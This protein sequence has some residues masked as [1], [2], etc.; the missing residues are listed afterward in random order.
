MELDG[1]PAAGKPFLCDATKEP[2]IWAYGFRN[3]FRFSFRPSNGALYLGDVGQS[4]REELDVVVAGGNYGW[5]IGGKARSTHHPARANAPGMHPRCSTT[6]SVGT[7]VTGGA[8][9]TGTAY[10][11]TLLQGL[12]V[13][14]DNVRNRIKYLQFD[15]NDGLIGGVNALQDSQPPL[16]GPVAFTRARTNPLLRGHQH[17]RYLPD[18]RR[19]GLLHA[20]PLPRWRTPEE[21]SGASRRTEPRRGRRPHLPVA[22]GLRDPD[23]RARP[24]RQPHRGALHGR[25]RDPFPDGRAPGR[26]RADQLPSRTDAGEQRDRHCSVDGGIVV[27]AGMASGG[28]HLIVDV[29]GYFDD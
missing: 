13:F 11:R 25:I 9:V 3:P 20:Q 16:K 8:F 19:Q 1:S 26:W 22:P 24:G 27:R 12:Y 17:R 7:T 28:V 23:Q 18:R 4:T 10:R 21:P 6:R 2:R 29:N 5:P 14:G 15:S